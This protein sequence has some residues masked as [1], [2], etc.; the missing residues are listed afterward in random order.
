MKLYCWLSRY[1]ANDDPRAA[2]G[3]FVALLIVS[4]QPFYPLYVYWLVGNVAWVAL[5]SFISTPFFFAVPALAK[6]NAVAGRVLLCVTG[7]FNTALCVWAF[8]SASGVGLFYLPCI[9]LGVL[10]FPPDKRVAMAFCTGLPV[11]AYWFLH[12]RLGA[13][14]HVFG[15]EQYSSLV[16]LHAVSVGSLIAVIGY[17][18][19]TLIMPDRTP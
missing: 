2:L 10:L 12:N 8:G 7:S 13:P 11:A 15:A 14:L 9:L 18:F 16:T 5:V 1:A 17:K 4:N 3:N 19:S 6:R